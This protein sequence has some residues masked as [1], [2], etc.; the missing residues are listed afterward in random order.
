VTKHDQHFFYLDFG[1]LKNRQ[2]V[3]TFKKRVCR[4]KAVWN[5]RVLLFSLER[6]P[7]FLGYWNC[8]VNWTN[9]KSKNG[10]RDLYF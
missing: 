3:A 6:V 5:E 4:W 1:Q 9:G 10:R 7:I 8:G 2:R